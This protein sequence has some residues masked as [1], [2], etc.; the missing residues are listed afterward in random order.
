MANLK[1]LRPES[2]LLK[3]VF[4]K[5]MTMFKRVDTRAKLEKACDFLRMSVVRSYALD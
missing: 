4:T 3:E 1:M 5:L 2:V